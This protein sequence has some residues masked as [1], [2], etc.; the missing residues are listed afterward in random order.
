MLRSALIAFN[1]VVALSQIATERYCHAVP[2]GVI[3]GLLMM[4][5]VIDRI[6]RDA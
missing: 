2:S 5:W 1:L 4:T 6:E 3:A